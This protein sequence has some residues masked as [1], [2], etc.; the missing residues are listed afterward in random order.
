[1]VSLLKL[2]NITEVS[3]VVASCVVLMFNVTGWSSISIAS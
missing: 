1:M 3:D 2:A